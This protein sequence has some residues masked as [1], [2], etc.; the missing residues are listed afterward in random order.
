MSD[1]K[2]KTNEFGSEGHAGQI[3]EYVKSMQNRIACHLQKHMEMN[4]LGFNETCREMGISPNKLSSILNGSANLTLNSIAEISLFLG[5]EPNVIFK[6]ID[7]TGIISINIDEFKSIINKKR[8]RID[9]LHTNIFLKTYEGEYSDDVEKT[10]GLSIN[11]NSIDHAIRFLK[12]NKI[13]AF[14]IKLP[15]QSY[16]KNNIRY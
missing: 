4:K 15:M 16:N 13:D 5:L 10:Y 9:I 11:F 14:K 7:N 2:I 6:P 12:E 3:N 8:F 1:K